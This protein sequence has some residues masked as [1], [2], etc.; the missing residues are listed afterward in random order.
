[1]PVASVA[2]KTT[3]L[4]RRLPY[5]PVRPAQ[6]DLVFARQ[7][8]YAFE[9]GPLTCSH[10]HFGNAGNPRQRECSPTLSMSGLTEL[11]ETGERR[12]NA[13]CDAAEVPLSGVRE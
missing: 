13:R 10:H 12:L 7:Q 9:T 5:R 3:T 11:P 2:R 8:A 4:R 1:M 6:E